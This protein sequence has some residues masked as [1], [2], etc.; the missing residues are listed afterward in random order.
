MIEL[1]PDSTFVIQVVSFLIFWQIMK[2]VLFL[3]LQEVLEARAARMLGDQQR[4]EA[5]RAEGAALAEQMGAA[6]AEARREGMRESEE[7]RRRAEGDEQEI[8]GS[9]RAAAAALLEEERAATG[10]QVE[11]ARSTLEADAKRL[12]AGVVIKVLGRAA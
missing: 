5:S 12:A 11:A 3:P 2:R 10:V 4:A 9:F 7:I 8:L 6:L 1:R